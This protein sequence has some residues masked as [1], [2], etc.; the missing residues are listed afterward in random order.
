M[1]YIKLWDWHFGRT[2]LGVVSRVNWRE[3]TIGIT[4]LYGLTLRSGQLRVYLLVRKCPEYLKDYCVF[5]FQELDLRS[6]GNTVRYSWYSQ[7]LSCQ[8]VYFK[9]L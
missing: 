8:R 4:F 6:R 5:F 9:Y 2:P 7:P 3:Q 1:K